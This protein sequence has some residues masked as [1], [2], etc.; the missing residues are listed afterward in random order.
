VSAG[1]SNSIPFS[2]NQPERPKIDLKVK[3]MG[4]REV[5]RTYAA[6][7]AD[8]SS[9]Y[10]TT[11]GIPLRRGRLFDARDTTGSQ[12]TV[13]VSEGAAQVLWPG[14]D[15]IGQELLWGPLGAENPYCTV[16]GVV[17]NVKQ[18]SAEADGSLELYYPYSQYPVSNVYYVVRTRG[19]PEALGHAVRDVI[20]QTDRSAAIVFLRSMSH[21]IDDTLWQRRLWGVMFAVFAALALVLA[22][23]G[24]YGVLS[25]SVSLRT[26]DLGIRLALGARPADVLRLVIKEGMLLSV[27]GVLLGMAAALALARLVRSLLFG[28]AGHDPPTFVAVGLVLLGVSLLACYIP[29]RRAARLEPVDALR[30]E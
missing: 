26:R 5:G 15:P 30:H 1:A 17:G 18:R 27:V 9:D 7:G 14:R 29:A 8:V 22:A 20:N 24:I 11:M 23:I 2:S 6:A 21:L 10:F 4:D 12:M 3:G 28:T 16:V 19:E 13:I 25:Y